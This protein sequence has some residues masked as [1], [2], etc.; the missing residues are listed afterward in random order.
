MKRYLVMQHGKCTVQLKQKIKLFDLPPG[1]RVIFLVRPAK[2]GVYSI[3]R[4]YIE[5]KPTHIKPKVYSRMGA[6]VPNLYLGHDY[7]VK[8]PMI[9]H[10][11]KYSTKHRNITKSNK[12]VKYTSK[13]VKNIVRGTNLALVK[14]IRLKYTTTDLYSLIHKLG[15]GEYIVASCRRFH[16]QTNKT[17]RMNKPNQPNTVGNARYNILRKL[18]ESGGMSSISNNNKKYLNYRM[19]IL[20]FKK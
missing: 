15:P 20:R 13:S 5:G 16:E 12:S 10:T 4:N 7:N 18:N 17:N 11:W 1:V 2:T 8:A 3:I 9:G 6:L 14:S 19:P